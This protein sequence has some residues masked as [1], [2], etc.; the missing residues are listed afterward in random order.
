M[1]HYNVQSAA[2]QKI[3][4]LAGR[5]VIQARDIFDLYILSSQFDIKEPKEIKLRNN[6]L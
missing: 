4:A 2:M 5:S 1:I 6:Q 3:T